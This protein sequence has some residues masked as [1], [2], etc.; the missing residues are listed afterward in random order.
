MCK[1]SDP[2]YGCERRVVTTEYNCHSHCKEYAEYKQ[3]LKDKSK[4]I[5]EKRIEEGII[6]EYVVSSAARASHKKNTQNAW[7]K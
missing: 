3:K 1:E 4:A 6:T 7:N 5:R 2:C